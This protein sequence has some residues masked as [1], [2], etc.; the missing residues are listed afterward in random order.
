MAINE[1]QARID[2][3]RAVIN[4][5][6]Y[7]YHVLDRQEISDAALDSLKRELQDLE[8]AHP[9][10]ITSDSPTQRVAGQALDKFVKVTHRVAQWSFDDAFTP[11]DLLTFDLRVKKLLKESPTYVSELKI[12]GFKI[13]L[14]YE[15]GLLVRAATRGD[16]QIGEDVTQNV[17]TIESIPLRLEWP[18]N[19]VVEG[20]VWLSRREFARLNREQTKRG[21]PLYA[22][23]RNVAAGTIRQLNPAVVAG[24]RL[25]SFI[26][27]LAAGDFPLPATQ[28]AELKLLQELG[29]KVNRHYHLSR[30]VEAAITFWQ[31]WQSKR[32]QEEYWLDGIVVKVNER[33]YQEQLGYTGKAPR[34]AIAFKFPAAQATTLIENI[35]FQVGRTGVVTP[36]AQLKPVLLAGST[37]SRATLHNEDEIKRLD[38]RLGDTVVVQ[39]AGDIIPDIV[40]VVKD[41]RRASAKPFVFP[42]HL[43]G[44]GRI[45]RISGAAAHRLVDKHSLA[46]RRR[47]FYY[48]VGKQAF[49]IDHF[50]P[51]MVDALLA[52]GLVSTVAD[53]FT[54]T[55][56]DLLNLPRL[57]EKSATNLLA[58]IDRARQVSLPR[59]IVSLSI[60]QVGEETALDLARHFGSL[61]KL[62]TAPKTTLENISGVGPVV[63]TAVNDWF[64]DQ[65]NQRLIKDLLAMVKIKTMMTT[66]P[67]GALIGKTIV[68]TGTLPTLTRDQAKKLVRQ[69]GGKVGSTISH[70]TDYLLAGEAPGSKYATAKK[71]GIKI[72]NEK[73]FQTR[74]SQT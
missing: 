12:D 25:D 71:L 36:V 64:T 39:K 46:Q 61:K 27:D 73:Q 43:P 57:A 40:S 53:I 60:S 8:T 19:I 32:D 3:L 5:Q 68:L 34:F 38:L 6:R 4:H 10:L 50:G 37:V 65:D 18:V 48:F 9:K 67:T 1:I 21:E 35:T 44:I 20:E 29:F 31:Q 59:F 49:D 23:P 51:K 33:H 28:L 56:G 70:Q 47:R 69:A 74:L 14:T 63:A 58:A 52:H 45:K 24:R 2:K 72:I 17:R 15:R 30:T 62:M 22:N 26:Y 42:N 7:L 55:K 66:Q 41:L 16:G 11:D 54:L 13:V